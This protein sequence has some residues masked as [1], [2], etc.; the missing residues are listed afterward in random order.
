MIE[1]CVNCTR[2]TAMSWSAVINCNNKEQNTTEVSQFRHLENNS[3]HKG[4]THDTCRL[5]NNWVFQLFLCSD[6]LKKSDL[7]PAGNFKMNC[8]I[9]FTK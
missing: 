8:I 1:V 7:I 9:K 2:S 6:H 3:V 5:V 4:C